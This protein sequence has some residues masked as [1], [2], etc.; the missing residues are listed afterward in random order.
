MDGI[1][2][3]PYQRP[4]LGGVNE[5][6]G[7]LLGYMRDPRRT[8]QLQGLAGLLESTGIPK[9]VE[10]LA[11]G[12]PLTNVQMANVP[13]FRPE[14]AEAAL[15]LLPIP[16]AANRAAMAAGRA[17]ERVAER[18][19]PRI[20]ERGGLPAGLLSDLAQG[21]RRQ[22]FVPATPDEAMA[23]SKMIKAGISP[24]EVWK[25]TGVARSPEGEWKKEI[26]DV[27]ATISGAKLPTTYIE[28]AGDVPSW[29]LGQVLSHPELYKSFPELQGIESSFKSGGTASATYNPG[30]NWISYNKEIFQKGFITKNQEDKI[31]KAKQ[32]YENFIKD[33]EFIKYNEKIEKAFDENKFTEDML[34]LELENKRN[35]LSDAYYGE[36]RRIQEA[37]D[38][39]YTLGSGQSA[40]GTTLHEVQ[41]AVQ[42]KSGFAVGGSPE[43]FKDQQKA[44]EARDVLGWAQQL[45]RKAAEMPGADSI[46]V[47]AALR[48][49]Y[50]AI[51]FADGIPNSEIRNKALQPSILYPEKYE[52]SEVPQLESLV[53]LYG[54]DKR[55]EPLSSNDVY[56]NLMGEAE[57]RLVERRMNLSPEQLRQYYPFEYTGKEGYGLDV[58]PE[59]LLYFNEKG[60]FIR[61]GLLD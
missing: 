38:Q 14:T 10:R 29:N 22:I 54:L 6:I 1:R 21:T 39:G 2:A 31:L 18:V 5:L 24:Q 57:A 15:T 59:D 41:H 56:R 11:Y 36:L 53:K 26:S 52:T 17:G 43:Q 33:P 44:I 50:E 40:K 19:V 27:G 30:M 7:G 46:A 34:N 45:R 48:K 47:D 8:Q 3:T 28:G 23:A 4:M 51:G 42:E 20:M 12:E 32:E 25:N 60:Q 61:R 58:K 37:G 35:K 55:T 16:P 49:D 9:T 13:L